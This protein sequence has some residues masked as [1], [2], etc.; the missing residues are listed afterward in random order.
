MQGGI[1]VALSE[2]RTKANKKYHEKFDDIKVRVPKGCRQTWQD[3]AAA[4]GESLNG[5][6]RRAVYETMERDKVFDNKVEK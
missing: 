1:F 3:H 2:A 5:F 6:I 4:N